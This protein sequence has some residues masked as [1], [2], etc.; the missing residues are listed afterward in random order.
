MSMYNLMFGSNPYKTI[1][2]GV[3]GLNEFDC[4]RFRDVFV[5]NGEIAIYTRNGGG[6]RDDYQHVFDTLAAHPNYL[7]NEDD[8]YD[9]TYAT[10]YFSI[11]EQFRGVL[12]ALDSGEFK[13]ED[14]WMDKISSLA[15]ETPDSLR[16]KY[17]QLCAIIETIN[18]SVTKKG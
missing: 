16:V 9:S 4:G 12:S 6:N 8:S 11:P 17:P 3:L 13:P 15:N 18:E 1:I 7:R 5:A 10:I 2:L 14:R